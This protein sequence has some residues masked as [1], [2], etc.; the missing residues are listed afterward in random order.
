MRVDRV[1]ASWSC[2]HGTSRPRENPQV[3]ASSFAKTITTRRKH[4]DVFSLLLIETMM[5][6]LLSFQRMSLTSK[7]H[8]LLF[9]PRILSSSS[10]S[11]SLLLLLIDHQHQR[12]EIFWAIPQL[13]TP[14]ITFTHENIGSV[15]VKVQQQQQRFSRR[16]STVRIVTSVH[17]HHHHH[18]NRHH[19]NHHNHHHYRELIDVATVAAMNHRNHHHYYYY[20]Y[21]RRSYH[22][23]VGVVARPCTGSGVHRRH[24]SLRSTVNHDVRPCHSN[25]IININTEIRM[26]ATNTLYG[27]MSGT[28]GT[29]T[30]TAKST[31]CFGGWSYPR[32][33]TIFSW[34]RQQQHHQQQQQ[35]QNYSHHHQ[36]HQHHQQ[37]QQNQ[38]SR[39]RTYLRD[40]G[41]QWTSVVSHPANTVPRPTEDIPTRSEQIQ[42]LKN[43]GEKLEQPQ[44]ATTSTLT[45]ATVSSSSSSS[46]STN[47]TFHYDILVVGGGA[48]GAGCALDAASRG[49]RVAAV[50]RG[51]F[52][53][54]TSSRATKL[55]WAGIK[56][57]GTATA[58]VLST[59]FLFH[60]INT[61]HEFWNEMKMVY[62]CHVE[63]RFMTHKQPHLCYWIPLVV[64]FRSWYID[65]PPLGHPLFSFFPILAPITFK[66]YD[67]L[68]AFTC[69][70]SYFITPKKLQR[71]FPQLDT[72]SFKYCAVFYEAGFNDA[73]TNV[74]IAMSAA[75]YGAHIANYVEVID[76][77]HKDDTTTT[78]QQHDKVI[79]AKVM[80]RMTGEIF[81]IYAKQVIL[82]CGPF[83]DHVREMEAS[84]IPESQS[85][86]DVE[87]NTETTNKTTPAVQ[88]VSGTHIVLPGYY[89]PKGM[90][91]L[92]ANT[93]D[94]RFMFIVPWQ[95]HTLIGTTDKKEPAQTLPQAPEEEVEWL[96]NEATK[97]FSPQIPFR[98]S[99]ITS[100][101]RGWRPL[102]A[103]P[104]ASHNAPASRDHVISENPQSGVIFVAGGKWT[105]WREMAQETIT[106]VVAKYKNKNVTPC[107]T[108]DIVLHGG[109]GYSDRLAIELLQLYIEL[110]PDVAEHLVHTY[111][112][113]ARKVCQVA[114]DQGGGFTRL[115]DNFPYIEAEI[116]FACREYACTVEDIL[117]RRT[118]LAFLNYRAA[119]SALDRVADIMSRELG[120]SSSVTKQQKEAAR[121]YIRSYQPPNDA[122]IDS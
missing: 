95:G 73:R 31:P 108:L 52:A 26:N 28:T 102:A 74:A 10:S 33:R 67:A 63:R 57:M 80:D 6:C 87:K 72:E 1:S 93:S 13:S 22:N 39:H 118:R 3:V 109:D 5:R 11:S 96:L 83:T 50:E 97:Y 111:G 9:P 37:H 21:C 47:D 78:N 100:A 18:Q 75:Q 110:T 36:R 41:L 38:S 116:I 69:P 49:L 117:S 79:G 48:T 112:G 71:I 103:D 122:S 40:P 84:D 64:P 2:R 94:G 61:I 86:N 30:V 27:G 90:G 62:H 45:A 107:R 17:H 121:Q 59:Q 65:P 76:L 29:S 101:W 70:P 104:H 23:I 82:A 19:H 119:E 56:Y 114:R 34:S 68:S 15:G 51:D 42:H 98:K 43:N 46:S 99:D 91:V 60:P 54:E 44:D 105:T 113:L 120:W 89:L 20:H 115:V 106:H 24:Y 66:L 55:I 4:H 92:D 32:R 85:T 16:K 88:G 14:I 58:R 77:L 35:Q 81:N 53:S 8:Q 25:N 7:C 12:H